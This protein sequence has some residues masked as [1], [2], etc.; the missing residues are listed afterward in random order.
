MPSEKKTKIQR[1]AALILFL[2]L[3]LSVVY[4]AVKLFVLPPA[5]DSDTLRTRSDYLLMLM[6]CIL[7]LCV[8]SLPSLMAKK[9]RLMLPTAIHV[10]YYA[11]LYCAVFLGEVFSFYDLIPCWDT[12]LHFSSGAMLAAL[13]VILIDF[14]N[15]EERI[16]ISLSPLFVSLFA[17]CFALAMGAVWEIY[18]YIADGLLGLNMQKFILADGTVL[19][20]RLALTDTMDDLIIDALAALIVAA[21]AYIFNPARKKTNP[22]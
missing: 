3:A 1:C 8:M 21:A 14:L 4:C 2:S 6:Q 9:W 10:M 12:I 19:S 7:G 11:F 13:G 15:H 17:F 18:E 16:R 20:G 5:S 22:R